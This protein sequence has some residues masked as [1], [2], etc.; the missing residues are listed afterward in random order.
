MTF[1]DLKN[2]FKSRLR[3]DQSAPTLNDVNDSNLQRWAF[4][5]LDT[6]VEMTFD[7]AI[8]SSLIEANKNLGLASNNSEETQFELPSDCF[9]LVSARAGLSTESIASVSVMPLKEYDMHDDTKPF[10]T[11]NAEFP[12]GTV[13]KS[14]I[15][16][17]PGNMTVCRLAY[18]KSH[19]YPAQDTTPLLLSQAAGVKL[20]DFMLF[21][22]YMFIEDQSK[23]Q[24]H[25]AKAM[26]GSNE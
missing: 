5:H 21:E 26:G 20:I 17:K 7:P 12:V 22:Y 3:A 19:P 4:N 13:A 2:N 10:T 18:R 9:N 1:A 24:L 23:A 16:I 6:V 11:P 15:R 8:H 25:L 14:K